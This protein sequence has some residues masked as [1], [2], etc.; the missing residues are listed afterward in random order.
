MKY[1]IIISFCLYYSLSVQ[2]QCTATQHNL[3][4]PFV[5]VALTRGQHDNTSYT[6]EDICGDGGWILA[7][8]EDFNETGLNG[9]L[10]EATW[11]PTVARLR[12]VT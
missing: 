12:R 7:W 3:S 1:F 9:A 11:A 10:N 8:E 6:E 4:G 5:D 2:A